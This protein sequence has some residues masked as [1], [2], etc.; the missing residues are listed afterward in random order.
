MLLCPCMNLGGD[1]LTHAEI[2]N[3]DAV[4]V[5]RSTRD[6][7]QST[8]ASGCWK[9]EGRCYRGTQRR[10]LQL[11]FAQ[12][13]SLLTDATFEHGS[14][15]FPKRK[16]LKKTRSL[17]L[18]HSSFCFCFDF[19]FKSQHTVFGTFSVYFV[20]LC[21]VFVLIFVPNLNTHN[22]EQKWKQKPTDILYLFCVFCVPFLFWFLFLIS[23]HKFWNK[24]ESIFSIYF[25]NFVF[26]FCFDFCC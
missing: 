24:N 8:S 15:F 3:Y 14:T 7:G 11:I 22:L 6:L 26:C 1:D 20:H 10:R 12:W 16:K 23:T 13:K 17:I 2:E 5:S 21:P 25:V 9:P 19:C 18:R 4:V